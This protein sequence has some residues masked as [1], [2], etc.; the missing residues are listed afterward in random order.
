MGAPHSHSALKSP[1][2]SFVFF[3]HLRSRT[4]SGKTPS[5]MAIED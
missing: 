3:L 5:P 4:D 2:K 1:D